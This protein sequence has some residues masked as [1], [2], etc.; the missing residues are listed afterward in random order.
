MSEKTKLLGISVKKSEDFSEWYTQVVLKAELC[1]YAP[2]HGCIVIREY[3]YAIWEKIQ[4][5]LD[6]KFKKMGVK[7]VYFPSLI[8][9]SLLT[10]EAEHFK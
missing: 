9:E 3:G 6:E 4:K 7:N 5:I 10:K 1:D 8:P 2:V